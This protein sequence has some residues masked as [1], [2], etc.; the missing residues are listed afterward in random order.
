[1]C[2]EGVIQPFAD[3]SASIPVAYFIEQGVY[4]ALF[5]LLAAIVG[6]KVI[7]NSSICFPRHL[8]HIYHNRT[9]P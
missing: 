2:L 3:Q 8:S 4:M 6:D 9:P 5:E 7:S 1:M